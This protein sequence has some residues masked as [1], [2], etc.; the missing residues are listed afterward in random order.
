MAGAPVAD[1]PFPSWLM[2]MPFVTGTHSQHHARTCKGVQR[3]HVR[4]PSDRRVF[5]RR[6]EG[7]IAVLL[8]HRASGRALVAACTHLFWCGPPPGPAP[9]GTPPVA[10]RAARGPW[11]LRARTR[12]GLSGLPRLY[13]ARLPCRNPMYPDVKAVQVSNGGAGGHGL[14]LLATAPHAPWSR[15]RLRV[16]YGTP[17]STEYRGCGLT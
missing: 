7:A 1:C 2:A 5:L 13:P 6:H 17:P 8:R 11:P 3:A 10:P 4:V 9:R 12:T 14:A 16:H 15:P